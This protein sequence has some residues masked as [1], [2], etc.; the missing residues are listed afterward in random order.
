M[1]AAVVHFLQV[2]VSVLV[3]TIAGAM[4]IRRLVS[5]LHRMEDEHN[6]KRRT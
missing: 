3:L 1:T 5:L 6:K 2:L 4:S